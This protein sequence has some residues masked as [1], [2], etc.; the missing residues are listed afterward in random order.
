VAVGKN[1]RNV[2]VL[3]IILSKSSFL[4]RFF[5]LLSG[6]LAVFCFPRFNGGG[7]AWICF[8]PLLMGCFYLEPMDAF[9]WGWGAGLLFNLGT[10]YWIYP[11][12][13]WASVSVPVAVLG[14]VSLSVYLGVYWAVFCGGAGVFLRKNIFLF[15]FYLGALWVSLELIRTHFLTG[16]PWL[17]LAYSQWHRPF[18][19]SL[20]EWGGAYAVSFFV[21][22]TNGVLVSVA[23]VFLD[24]RSWRTVFIGG[25]GFVALLSLDFYLW[26]KPHPQNNSGFSVALIQGNIDQY[27]KWNAF[28]EKSVVETYSR[29]TRWAVFSRPNLIVWP[30]TAVPGWVPND[31]IYLDWLTNLTK[32]T[33]A[34]LL[35]GA[36]TRNGGRD[37]NAV[38]LFSAQGAMVSSYFKQHLVPFG[39]F[40]PMGRFLGRWIKVLNALGGFSRGQKSSVLCGPVPLGVTVCF[41]GL[42]PDL[43]RRFVYN[44]AEILVNITNDGWYRD[45]AAPE[46]HLAANVLR[47]VENRR[48]LLRVANTGI[49]AVIDPWG[50]LVTTGPLLKESVLLAHVIP[51]QEKTFYTRYGNVFAGGC[52]CLSLFG[53]VF[54]KRQK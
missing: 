53:I 10:L 31:S 26:R 9:G 25:L 28:Y 24:R 30:E 36:V 8:L 34:Y 40:V 45:T 38:F 27:R 41:E 48:W 19:L 39:E 32:E 17:L 16:F 1:A 4:P 7:L 29:L 51:L 21:F 6:V 12:C 54:W 33:G 47:A 18:F 3:N 5:V 20:A 35:T 50:R 37:Y 52:F 15:P 44:G 13:R 43:V 14:L 23:L 49:S 11:T 22:F 46:Q 42:F 2:A